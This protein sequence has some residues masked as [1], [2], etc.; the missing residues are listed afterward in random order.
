M[1]ARTLARRIRP[2][3]GCA[4]AG[5]V[6][7]VLAGC[8]G[9]GGGT[10]TAAA[11]RVLPSQP[12]D[13]PTAGELV[14]TVTVT[15]DGATTV[16]PDIAHVSM[17]VSVRRDTAA[18]TLAAANESANALIAALE[19]LGVAPDDIRTTGISI[20]PQY[21]DAGRT[22]VG[23]QASN[24]L[25][26]TIRDLSR[27]GEIIDG[28]AAFAGEAIT[29]GGIWFSVDDPEAVMPEARAA[30]VENAAK[31][32]GEYAEAAGVEVGS[33]VSISEASVA[34][35]IPLYYEAAAD[36]AERSVPVRPGTQDLS[37]TVTVVYELAEG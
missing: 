2:A 37:V 29:I 11:V 17:G 22:V 14:R 25:D 7:L 36:S 12:D 20:F 13:Q 15:G 3:A 33:V 34:P 19:A 18:E 16:V 35:P 1:D 26:V 23:F 32:A 4:L 31:R 9:A 24:D 27:A 21:D 10:G 30:A 5:L 28:G 6:A 8:A